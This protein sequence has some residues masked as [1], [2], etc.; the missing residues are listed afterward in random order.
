[1]SESEETVGIRLDQNAELLFLGQSYWS[2]VWTRL[3]S[4]RLALLAFF[5]LIIIAVCVL[6]GPSISPY[7]YGKAELRDRL[8]PPSEAHWLGTD[9][10]GRDIVARL[11]QG[12]RISLFVGV[13]SALLS[14]V[15]GILIGLVSGY[16]GKVVDGVLMRLTDIMLSIPMLPLLLILS[17]LAGGTMWGIIAILVAFGWMSLARIV[18]GSVL[19]VREM[20]FVDAAYLIGTPHWRIIFVHIFPNILAPVIVYIT[21]AMGGA[22]LMESSLSYLGLGIQPPMPSWGNM[23][24]NAQLYLQ[25]APWLALYPGFCIFVV[26]LSF[27][28]VGDGLRDALDPRLKI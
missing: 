4:H 16:F 28:F 25:N 20:E 9:E 19:S 3:R 6:V 22:I 15:V 24:M 18:R 21:L 7:E 5:T 1:M 26:M 2:M 11:L 17:R 23:L 13:F 12:G 14:A 10:L 27:N 8:Q